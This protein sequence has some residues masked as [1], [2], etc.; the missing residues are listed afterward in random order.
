MLHQEVPVKEKVEQV[1]VFQL[2]LVLME[3][4]LEILDIFLLGEVQV[5]HLIILQVLLQEQEE[6]VLV[7][8]VPNHLVILLQQVQLNQEQ[9]IQVTAVV[10]LELVQDILFLV[11]VA[12][13]V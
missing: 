6:Q 5:I 1:E 13:L 9:Q 7:L 3:H 4:R 10:E 2:L 11:E 8:D 12:D